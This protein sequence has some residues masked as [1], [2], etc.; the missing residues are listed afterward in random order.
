[1]SNYIKSKATQT[2]GEELFNSITHGCGTL[3]SIAAL[4]ILTV[5]S[6][7]HGYVRMVVA[8]A[9]YGS[10][11]IILYLASTL[12]HIANKPSLKAKAKILDHASIFL[13]IAGTYTPFTLITLQGAWG[14][15]LFGC[16][17]GIALAGIIFK[18][19][20]TGRYEKLSLILYLVMGWIVVIAIHPLVQHLQ[21]KGIFLLLCG[22]LFY[23]VGTIFY[24]K[25]EK[26]KFS[27]AIWHLFVLAGSICHFFAILTY[28]VLPN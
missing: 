15:S 19:F 6:V 24:I 12:Y 28:V 10:T 8:T 3:L 16:T 21:P 7:H 27:H 20:F 23:T 18:I 1:M 4:V 11:L 5:I 2:R 14:W 26:Y 17:W 25:D 9:I 22:G 13:L